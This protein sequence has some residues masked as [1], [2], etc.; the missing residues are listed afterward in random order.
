MKTIQTTKV[1][2]MLFLLIM[3]I[4]FLMQDNVILLHLESLKESL[5]WFSLFELCFETRRIYFIYS[6]KNIKSNNYIIF[7]KF[8]PII[9]FWWKI[10]F[11]PVICIYK[12][13]N[14]CYSL[15]SFLISSWFNIT[16]AAYWKH[17]L[18]FLLMGFFVFWVFL[19]SQENLYM[20]I[21]IL[22]YFMT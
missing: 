9:F 22:V 21:T 12:R 16:V 7:L 6:I 2:I 10:Y 17:L 1:T 18:A 3:L 8:F 4:I 14:F 11:F 5:T 19:F 15:R 13:F 20:I